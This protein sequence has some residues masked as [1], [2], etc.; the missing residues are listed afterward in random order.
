MPVLFSL[1]NCALQGVRGV[2]IKKRRAEDGCRTPAPKTSL[3]LAGA[4]V[5]GCYITNKLVFNAHA[6]L[7]VNVF[8]RK[9]KKGIRHLYYFHSACLQV[10]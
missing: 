1:K 7:K 2:S 8:H 6:W 10:I 9:I 3:V 5:S 4:V